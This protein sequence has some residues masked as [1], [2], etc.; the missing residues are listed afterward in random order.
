MGKE[1]AKEQ[2]TKE[3]GEALQKNDLEKAKQEIEKLAEKLDK[4]SLENEKKE[5]EKKLADKDLSEQEKQELQKKL[6]DL[7]KEQPLSDKEKEQLQKKL[8]QVAKQMDKQDKDQKQKQETAAE[9]DGGRDP[10]ARE[11]EGAGED[12]QRTSSTPSASCRRRSDELKKL[13]KDQERQGPVG[14]A[15][16]AQAAAEATWRRPPRTSRS[17]NPIRTRART[18]R[19]RSSRSATSRP[20]AT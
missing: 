12:R 11:E 9:A 1:L 10:P 4:E 13:Q 8:D 3:L 6:D 20:H 14:A 2:V 5:L 19:I 18:S 15:R 16:G 17:R 7:K